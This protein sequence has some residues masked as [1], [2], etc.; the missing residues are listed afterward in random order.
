VAHFVVVPVIALHLV[1][2]LRFV[3]VPQFVAV[4]VIALHL[5]AALRFVVLPQFVVVPHFAGIL[6]PGKRDL[7]HRS[8]AIRSARQLLR[9]EEAHI[10]EKYDLLEQLA[11]Q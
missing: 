9:E 2:A 6:S 7:V 4:P 8:A 1:A 10:Q 11:G 5:V 3:V